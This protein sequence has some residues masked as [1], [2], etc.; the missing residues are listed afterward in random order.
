M[1]LFG[2]LD[3][4]KLFKENFESE[5]TSFNISVK[6]DQD[7]DSA[8]RVGFKMVDGRFRNISLCWDFFC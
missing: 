7:A 5:K 6:D 2:K 1:D 4:S 3:S 8:P